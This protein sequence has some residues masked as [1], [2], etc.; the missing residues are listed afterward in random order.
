MARSDELLDLA[1]RIDAV[2]QEMYE[3][4]AACGAE[5]ADLEQIARELRDYVREG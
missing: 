4:L 1:N 3:N 5:V 2:A